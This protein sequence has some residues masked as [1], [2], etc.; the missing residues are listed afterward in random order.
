MPLG[1]DIITWNPRRGSSGNDRY[2][3][4]DDTAIKVGSSSYSSPPTIDEVNA[5]SGINQIIAEYNRRIPRSDDIVDPSLPNLITRSYI[6]PGTKITGTLLEAIR[7]NLVDLRVKNL[8]SSFSFTVSTHTKII[9]KTMDRIPDLRKALAL[10]HLVIFPSKSLYTIPSTVYLNA[11]QK[12]NQTLA[13]YIADTGTTILVSGANS[14]AGMQRNTSNI[15]QKF[16]AYGCFKP[17]FPSISGSVFSFYS[18]AGFNTSFNVVLYQTSTDIDV[19]GSTD[20]ATATLFLDSIAASSIDLTAATPNDLDAGT[21]MTSGSNFA[22][23]LTSDEAVAG[24]DPGVNQNRYIRV[25]F[26]T[27]VIHGGGM[28]LRIYT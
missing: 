11:L 10:D 3:F 28:I 21:N 7:L 23:F 22:C 1:T 15:F 5:G 12:Q 8:L 24:T 13:Q 17:V 20:W 2:T 9:G 18:S 16:R 26:P 6:S 27:S 4:P 25:S 19:L 14:N